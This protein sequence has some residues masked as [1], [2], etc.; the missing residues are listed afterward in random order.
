M[1]QGV[2]SISRSKSVTQ[3]I[4]I[5]ALAVLIAIAA[6][7]NYLQGE[8]SG[9]INL[10]IPQIGQLRSLTETPLDLPGWSVIYHEELQISR[11]GWSHIEYQ[12]NASEADGTSSSISLLLRAPNAHDQ[13]P[14]VEW[15]DI[16]GAGGWQVS[17][18][19]RV[20]FSV[21]ANG[22]TIPVTARYSRGIDANSTF[23]IMQ[24]YAWPTS[25]HFAP[26]RWFWADQKQ[27]WQQRERMPWVAVTLLLPIEPVGDIRTH[28][29]RMTD[30]AQTIQQSLLSTVLSSN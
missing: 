22:Q 24:W 14:E 3:W 5:A 26:G 1:S 20:Q 28:T 7:P 30:I 27:Q 15:V 12:S 2:K 4:L 6:I 13:Q 29:E 16:Q 25:G 18:V 23:A 9:S 21:E 11:K 17:D 19:H 10:K 8:W